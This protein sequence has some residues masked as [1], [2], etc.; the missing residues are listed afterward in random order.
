MRAKIE[1]FAAGVDEVQWGHGTHN[2][3]VLA[4]MPY[5]LSDFLLL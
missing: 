5:D 3:L 4:V 2:Y 1:R